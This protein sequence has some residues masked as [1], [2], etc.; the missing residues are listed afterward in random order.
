MNTTRPLAN[1]SAVP[2][3][4]DVSVNPVHP[5]ASMLAAMRRVWLS[6][7]ANRAFRAAQ[8]ELM[9]LDNH[10]LKDIGL[11]RSEIESALSDHTGERRNAAL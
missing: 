10:A 1:D 7:R 5:F 11:D 2:F 3:A 4:A 9:A 6:Y 8:A